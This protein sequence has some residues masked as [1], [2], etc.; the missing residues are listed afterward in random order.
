MD[1][2]GHIVQASRQ[3]GWLASVPVERCWDSRWPI[4]SATAPTGAARAG[5][6]NRKASLYA[7]SIDDPRRARA[8]VAQAAHGPRPRIRRSRSSCTRGR[9]SHRRTRARARHRRCVRVDVPAGA[10]FINSLQQ[11]DDVEDS[12]RLA[13]QKCRITGF[14]RTMVYRVRRRGHGHVLAES[15][16]PGYASYLGQ[17]FPASDIPQAGARCTCATASA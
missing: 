4:C 6:L 2:A 15:L 9:A 8:K 16:D 7:G 10:H 14:G 1:D 5:T 17:R 13:A 3:R 12:P 11:V